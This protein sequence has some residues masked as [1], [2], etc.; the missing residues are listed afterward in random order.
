MLFKN[1]VGETLQRAR[2]FAVIEK[3]LGF[4]KNLHANKKKRV[5]S[6]YQFCHLLKRAK[7]LSGYSIFRDSCYFTKYGYRE[8][9]PKCVCRQDWF[10]IILQIPSSGKVREFL[11]LCTAFWIFI[12]V[13][14][15]PIIGGFFS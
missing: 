6:N 15:L 9:I 7:R 2:D 13:N 10:L 4:H 8:Q 11:W 14:I 5:D 3:E 12:F 1:L